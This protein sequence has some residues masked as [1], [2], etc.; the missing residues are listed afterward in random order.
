M[1]TQVRDEWREDYDEG[2]GGWGARQV[3]EE[4]R[5]EHQRDVYSSNAPIPMGGNSDYYG[6]DQNYGTR[7]LSKLKENEA[8]ILM[9]T[10]RSRR[11]GTDQRGIG[12][13][14]RRITKVICELELRL[15]LNYL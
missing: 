13:E 5:A 14:M 1:V 8:E 3:E 6:G 4:M 15:F 2:R 12:S 7:N 9:M 11:R 10:S